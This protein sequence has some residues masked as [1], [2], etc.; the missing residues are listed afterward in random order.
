VTEQVWRAKGKRQLL[1]SSHNANLVVNGDA[2]LVVCC[3]YRVA[4][5]QSSGQIKRLGA[6]D[7]PEIRNEITAIMEGGEEAFKLRRDK[8]GF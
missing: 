6:I 1:F 8:Y 2:E 4:G 3:D 5:E 7:I